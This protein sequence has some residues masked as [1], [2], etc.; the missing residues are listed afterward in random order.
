QIGSS[1]NDLLSTDAETELVAAIVRNGCIQID[2]PEE[3]Q[4]IIELGKPQIVQVIVHVVLDTTTVVDVTRA[5]RVG[6]HDAA[7]VEVMRILANQAQARIRIARTTD[8]TSRHAGKG[9]GAGQIRWWE[10]TRILRIGRGR[11]WWG[12]WVS[13]GQNT[14]E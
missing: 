7:I 8:I 12:V 6:Q 11:E 3:V 5:C 2:L 1:P 14:K 13:G 4:V 9:N 10:Q